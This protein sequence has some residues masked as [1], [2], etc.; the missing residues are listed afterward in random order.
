[1][2]SNPSLGYNLPNFNPLTYSKWCDTIGMY[3]WYREDGTERTIYRLDYNWKPIYDKAIHTADVYFAARV[4]YDPVEFTNE[5]LAT[6]PLA[7]EKYKTSLELIS[8]MLDGNTI[9]PEYFEAGYERTTEQTV[10]GTSKTDS[11][12]T[13]VVGQRVDS[14]DAENLERQLNY[15]QGVQALDGQIS[16][17]NIG[18]LGN[19]KASGIV[20]VVNQS[21][22]TAVT[23][24]QT[25][26]GEGKSAAETKN[27]LKENV[28]E[29]RFNYYDNLAFLRDRMV[30]IDTVK[31]FYTYFN[32]LF[33]ASKRMEGWW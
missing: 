13:A 12:T 5:F 9:D 31:P 11:T 17:G 18:R 25:N 10:D 6:V 14:N 22:N 33:Y 23:G 16:N 4:I 21:N 7:W 15:Q 29:K 30:L 32:D 19:D 3:R 2:Y 8:G 27:V 28:R 1:M 24:P 26:T 20:D